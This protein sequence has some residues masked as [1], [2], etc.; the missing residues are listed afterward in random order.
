MTLNQRYLSK[1]STLL[2]FPARKAKQRWKNSC[3]FRSISLKKSDLESLKRG[4]FNIEDKAKAGSLI[5]YLLRSL[6]SLSVELQFRIKYTSFPTVVSQSDSSEPH[7]LS[8]S[9]TPAGTSVRQRTVF[10]Q[11]QFFFFYKSGLTGQVHGYHFRLAEF[12]N[13]RLTSSSCLFPSS[14]INCY[15]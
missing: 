9:S 8:L 6:S 3:M 4:H 10:A 11:Y 12:S 1:L 13:L 2:F 14:D 15:N 7:W 5:E